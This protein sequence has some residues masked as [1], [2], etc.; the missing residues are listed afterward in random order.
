M[1]NRWRRW[2]TGIRGRLL[3]GFLMLFVFA[4]GVSGIITGF[5]GNDYLHN[6]SVDKLR[7][8]ERRIT[9]L[10]QSGPQTINADQFETMLGPPLGIMGLSDDGTVLFAIGTGAGRES[11]LARLARDAG[12]SELMVTSDD[13]VAVS[14][15]TPAMRITHNDR[16]P[17]DV[18]QLIL[19]NDATI[20]RSAVIGFARSM[21]VIAI[22]AVI[23]LMALAVAV[24]EI[25]LRP[26]AAMVGA[27]DRVARGSLDERL[28]VSDRQSETDVL[29]LAVNRALD[30][31]AHAEDRARTF[32]ADASHELRTP[33]ATIS[34]WLELY[35]QGGLPADQIEQALALL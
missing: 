20:D 17:D 30:A 21:A 25:G 32:A 4:L 19:I 35:R 5:L 14:I 7:A 27:A 11:E 1:D 31:Q 2:R 16:A 29:G 3:V 6:R 33:V 15:P 24:L 9:Q 34:G 26:L 13:V 10:V 23:V 28:P 8:D 22:V 12:P 18:A